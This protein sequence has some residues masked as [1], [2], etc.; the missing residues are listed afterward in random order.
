[1]EELRQKVF[2]RVERIRR[3]CFAEQY[4]EGRE[5]NLSLLGNRGDVQVLPPAEI[6]FEGFADEKPKIVGYRAKWAAESAEYSGTPRTF[7]FPPTDRELL[8]NLIQ[9]ARLCWQHFGLRGYARVDF[10]VDAMGRPWILE[11]NANPCLSPDAGYAAALKEANIP[12]TTAIERILSDTLHV[13]RLRGPAA[14][15]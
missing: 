9:L 14:G 12:F 5:F 2:E 1:V 15:K 7:Q 10:R 13:A 4:I 11:I 6:H 8:D 3:P